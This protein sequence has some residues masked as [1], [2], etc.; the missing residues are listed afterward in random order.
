MGRHMSTSRM[1]DQRN[2]GMSDQRKQRNSN[3]PR[4][5]S[6]SPRGTSKGGAEG[7]AR[8][9]ADVR[10]ARGSRSPSALL[11]PTAT[12]CLTRTRGVTKSPTAAT[13]SPQSPQAVAST[14]S[15]LLQQRTADTKELLARLH[16]KKQSLRET[17]NSQL[18]A[19]ISSTKDAKK[20]LSK[21]RTSLAGETKSL[22]TEKGKWEGAMTCYQEFLEA[23]TQMSEAWG[24]RPERFQE[25]DAVSAAIERRSDELT[26]TIEE[27]DGYNEVLD[28]L[29]GELEQLD[30]EVEEALQ[31]KTEGVSVDQTARALASGDSS[32]AQPESVMSHADWEQNNR[33]LLDK[34]AERMAHSAEVRRTGHEMRQQRNFLEEQSG[35]VLLLALEEQLAMWR[36]A[37]KTLT[38]QI[39]G[40]TANIAALEKFQGEVGDKVIPFQQSLAA[41]AG[42][43]AERNTRPDAERKSD[44]AED[45]LVN[46]VEELQDLIAQLSG[47][48]EDTEQEL[49]E[50]M[51]KLTMLQE[52]FADVEAAC[53]VDL[54][55]REMHYATAQ[56]SGR[57]A[58]LSC[59]QSFLLQDVKSASPKGDTRTERR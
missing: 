38:K 30:G 47:A 32:E 54:A 6:S 57:L 5:N 21:A 37:R 55:C 46:E 8:S 42:R 53:E 9:A 17:S 40:T 15:E 27:G 3:S 12:M 34:V 7:N 4:A 14:S 35:K 24:E 18:E 39:E 10:A 2:G 59:Q 56:T 1:S 48:D 58:G 45:A 43:L 19:A 25:S 52:E 31:S 23:S 49:Q 26:A 28:A 50:Q 20:C 22:T 44:V 41:A 16:A 51:E 13:M 29:L 33:V 11:S 36:D